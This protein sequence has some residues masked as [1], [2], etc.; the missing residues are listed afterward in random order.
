MP[1]LRSLELECGKRSAVFSTFDL[2][3]AQSIGYLAH[4]DQITLV[5]KLFQGFRTINERVI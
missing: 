2:V 5:K 3:D 1:C 4:F